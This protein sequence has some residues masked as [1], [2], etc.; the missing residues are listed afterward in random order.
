M[1]QQPTDEISV[2]TAT[3]HMKSAIQKHIYHPLTLRVWQ[4]LTSSKHVHV[5]ILGFT[6][7]APPI[8]V[9]ICLTASLHLSAEY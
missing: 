7:A 8:S 5:V 9:V 1:Q 3:N 2:Q 4:K 6:L